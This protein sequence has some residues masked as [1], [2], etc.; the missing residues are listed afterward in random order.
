MAT[1]VSTPSDGN[2]SSMVTKRCLLVRFCQAGIIAELKKRLTDE[3]N[4][5]T[6]YLPLCRL[7]HNR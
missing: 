1:V 2:E 6:E 7:H 3:N 4:E 5:P